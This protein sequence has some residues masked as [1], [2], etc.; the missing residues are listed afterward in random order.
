MIVFDSGGLFF[1][2]FFL[3]QVLFV[4]FH[5]P[6]I[7]R[8]LP[9]TESLIVLQRRSEITTMANRIRWSHIAFAWLIIWLSTTVSTSEWKF[10]YDHVHSAKYWCQRLLSQLA[11]LFMFCH[12]LVVDCSVPSLWPLTRWRCFIR[13]TMFTFCSTARPTTWRS[14]GANCQDVRI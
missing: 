4:S 9:P 12:H 7:G 13:T 1:W 6:P 10:S 14:T 3:F 8:C 5:C 11:E 2:S